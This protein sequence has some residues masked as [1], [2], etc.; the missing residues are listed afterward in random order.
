MICHHCGGDSKVVDSRQREDGSVFRRRECLECSKRFSSLETL[1]VKKTAKQVELEELIAKL[2]KHLI[3]E[4]TPKVPAKKA[5]E[6]V[7]PEPLPPSDELAKLI[8]QQARDDK[9]TKV[10]SNSLDKPDIFGRDKYDKTDLREGY[11]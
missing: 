7:T 11:S 8:E 2:A 9:S 3:E 4:S 6:K 1:W 5:K 10:W